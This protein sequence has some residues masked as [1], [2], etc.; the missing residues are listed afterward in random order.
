MRVASSALASPSVTNSFNQ[1]IEHTPQ[2]RPVRVRLGPVTVERKMIPRTRF[3]VAL[4]WVLLGA[5]CSTDDSGPRRSGIDATD[6]SF[7]E[8]P[9]TDSTDNGTDVE[10]DSA[11]DVGADENGGDGSDIVDEPQPTDVE[12]D[13]DGVTFD[14]VDAEVV[15]DD[16]DVDEP[17]AVDDPDVDEPD[18]DP[19]VVSDPDLDE[20][21]TEPDEAPDIV[22]DPDVVDEPDVVEPDPCSIV[23]TSCVHSGDLLIRSAFDATAFASSG[24][25]VVGGDVLVTGNETL[26]HLEGLSNLEWVQGSLRIVRSDSLE[27]IDGLSA[28]RVIGGDL[29][30]GGEFFSHESFAVMGNAVLTNTDGL[31]HLECIGEDA[32]FVRL[33]AIESIRLPSLISLG[34]DLALARN[35]RSDELDGERV[36]D[37]AFPLL[38][39]VPGNL[40]IQF[41]GLATFEGFGALETVGGSLSLE[42]NVIRWGGSTASGKNWQLTTMEPLR[43]LRSVGGELAIYFST[44]LTTLGGESDGLNASLIFVGG[45]L[46]IYSNTALPNCEAQ[47]LRDRLIFLDGLDGE[48]YINDNNEEASCTF[49]P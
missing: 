7:R 45:E 35:L 39:D 9:S 29:E 33:Y 5:A 1:T 37:I 12:S 19:D 3:F 20:E 28:L 47:Y 8:V 11:A 44:A 42:D 46:R 24:C 31:S 14:Q 17:D 41:T 10:D 38:T 26:T 48:V 49:Y 40:V 23:P 18:E 34:D 4:V 22:T 2:Y 15:L 13:E 21:P 25:S 36:V 6:R 32:Q 30:V 43:N 27:N 16:P